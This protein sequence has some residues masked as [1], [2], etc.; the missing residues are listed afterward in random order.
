MKLN[1]IFKHLV[2]FI[3]LLLTV[4]AAKAQADRWQQR[5]KY[6]I[7]VD[8]NVTINRFTGTET[9]LEVDLDKPIIPHSRTS[10]DMAFSS[11]IPV[12]IRR[13][14][15]DNAEGIRYTMSQWYPKMAEYDYE[16]W[17]ADPYIAREFYGVWG[18][19][20]VNI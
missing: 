15:R 18:D 5:I 16:G 19:F 14:G 17:N 4:T 1:R 11:Q 10:L 20:D 8:M 2:A 13:S 6:V 9:I 3:F 7:N 12:Q